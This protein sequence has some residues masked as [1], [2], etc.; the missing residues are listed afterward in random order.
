MKL[1]KNMEKDILLHGAD[2]INSEYMQLEKGFL[3][4][5]KVTVFEHSLRVA[6]LSIY[7]AKKLNI[8]VNK[9]SLIRGALLHDYFLYDW[10]IADPS[11][12][13]HGF[14]H[15]KRALSNATRDF[16]LNSIEKDIIKKHMFPLNITP[17]KYRES[18]IVCIAD[19]ISALWEMLSYIR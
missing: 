17:P 2:I 13:F 5:G 3:Q 18:I 12:R 14:I 7:I 15:A 16:S 9:R 6:C 11:H 19:K 1:I 8:N 4:H 10:H